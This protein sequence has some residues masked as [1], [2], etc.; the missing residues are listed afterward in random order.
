MPH[1]AFIGSGSMAS[2]MAR[3]LLRSGN[4]KP[5]QLACIGGSGTSSLQLSQELGIRLAGSPQALLDDAQTVV[6]A[7]KPQVF[8]GLDPAYGELARGKLVVSVLAGTRLERLRAFFPAARAIVRAMPNT[9]GAIGHGMTAWTSLS[10][11]DEADRERLCR[12]LAGLGDSVEVPETQLDAITAVS[13]SGPG[14]FFEFLAAYE[15]GAVALGLP[16]ELARRLIRTTFVGSLALAD[17]TGEAPARLRDQVTS[18][19]G[20]TRA[21]LDILQGAHFDDLVARALEA[22]RD[23]ARELS[24]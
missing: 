24:R 10:P 5:G 2:A 23:R 1:Y 12:L 11:L 13:G 17:A 19:N 15:R 14:F 16:P 21:G 18:P 20:T 22:A 4:A 8:A 9:P 3:G 7:C 6:V